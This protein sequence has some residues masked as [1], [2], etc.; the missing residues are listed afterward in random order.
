MNSRAIKSRGRNAENAVV[1]YLRLRGIEAERRRL[2][3]IDDMGDIGGWKGVVVEVKDQRKITLAEYM[4]ELEA[5]IAN[6]DKRLG[7]KHIGFAVQK[8]KGCPTAG[9]W[10]AVMPLAALVDLVLAGREA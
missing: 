8:R 7:G 2:T 3:G 5:E 10:Y 9:D 4:D 6:A 1:E